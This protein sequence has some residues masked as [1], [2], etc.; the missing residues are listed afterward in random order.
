MDKT[1]VKVSY[2]GY[3]DILDIGER[4]IYGDN[5]WYMYFTHKEYTQRD[6][7][8]VLQEQNKPTK[9]KIR[10]WKHRLLHAHKHKGWETKE[11]NRRRKLRQT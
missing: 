6:M 1:A 8:Y 2:V 11:E 4:P 7:I 5:K 3:G 10:V 9:N